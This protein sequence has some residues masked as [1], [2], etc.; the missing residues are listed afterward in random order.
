MCSHRP[1]T[2]EITQMGWDSFYDQSVSTDAESQEKMGRTVKE[3]GVF[4]TKRN[5][6]NT[7]RYY[8]EWENNCSRFLGESW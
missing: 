4:F 8:M 6:L 7:W 1:D 2:I 5:S 3:M